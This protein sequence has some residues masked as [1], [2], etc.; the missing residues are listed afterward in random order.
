MHERMSESRNGKSK[1]FGIVASHISA[2]T[3]QDVESFLSRD[4]IS[5]IFIAIHLASKLGNWNIFILTVLF[6]TD[7]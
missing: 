1:D 6:S 5:M 2:V 7:K 3:S 4:F